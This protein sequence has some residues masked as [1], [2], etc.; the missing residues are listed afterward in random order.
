MPYKS[1]AQQ[2]YLHANEPEVAAKFDKETS[3]KQFENLPEKAGK[4]KSKGAGK[5]SSKKTSKGK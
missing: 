2:A 3:K 1:K 4:G 5:S